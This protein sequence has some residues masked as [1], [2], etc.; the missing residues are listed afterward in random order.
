MGCSVASPRRRLRLVRGAVVILVALWMTACGG[1][2][3]DVDEATR[4]AGAGTS[5]NWET[6]G[7]ERPP[8]LVEET[9]EPLTSDVGLAAEGVSEQYGIPIEEATRRMLLQEVLNARLGEVQRL[10]AGRVARAEF[11]HEPTFAAIV[12]L[13]GSEPIRATT[14]ELLCATPELEVRLGASFTEAELASEVGRLS[15]TLADFG[16]GLIDYGPSDGELVFNV[17][18]GATQERL[19]ALL[20]ATTH[21][22]FSIESLDIAPLQLDPGIPF[23]LL[24]LSGS[25]S[26]GVG[27]EGVVTIEGSCVY[28]GDQLVVLSAR[29][30]SWD[31]A[32]GVLNTGGGDVRS[33]DRVTGG[34]SPYTRPLAELDQPPDPSCRLDGGVVQASFSPVAPGDTPAP[35]PPPLPPGDLPGIRVD[36]SPGTGGED[37]EVG[38]ILEVGEGCVWLNSNGVRMPVVWPALTFGRADP[39]EI[40]LPTGEVARPG[41]AVDGGGGYS[42]AAAATERLGLNPFP[43]QCIESGQA[44]VFSNAPIT[45]TP[46]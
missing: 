41:D 7:C 18:D 22:P 37:A 3:P 39:P 26:S 29:E 4:L 43:A 34:G 31:A 45:V 46:G 23:P 5:V 27:L 21:Y 35:T 15:R 36:P 32:T 9:M 20:A 40:V 12:T 19:E 42:D 13:I 11:Q 28:L 17:R 14:A 8:R 10:E 30:T 38:G 2:E 16:P 1:P 25:A 33:G 44:V 24:D 6:L